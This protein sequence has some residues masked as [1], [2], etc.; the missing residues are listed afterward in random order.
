[1]SWRRRIVG[2]SR[3][4]KSEMYIGCTGGGV[5]WRRSILRKAVLGGADEE[6][7][8]KDMYR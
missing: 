2:S 4:G 8:Y 1:M 3:R 7:L 5:I 6:V